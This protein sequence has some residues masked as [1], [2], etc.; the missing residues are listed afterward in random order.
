MRE[1]VVVHGFE[2]EGEGVEFAEGADEGGVEGGGFARH[3]AGPAHSV[4]ISLGGHGKHVTVRHGR[5]PLGVKVHVA[6]VAELCDSFMKEMLRN[7]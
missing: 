4:V 2:V 7:R 3:A 1:E 6:C 5:Y